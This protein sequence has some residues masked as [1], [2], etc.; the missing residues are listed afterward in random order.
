MNLNFIVLQNIPKMKSNFYSII[1]PIILVLINFIL[2]IRYVKY[3][4]LAKDEPFSLYFSQF[5]IV[6]IVSEL[7]KGNN[8]PLYEV[9]LHIWTSFFGISELAV[10]FPSVIFSSLTVYFIYHICRKFF[11]Q[12]AAILAALFFTLSNYEMY[13]AH[14]AR[15]YP[16]FLLLTTISM[17]QYLKLMT[18]EYSKA[19]IVTYVIVSILLLYSHFFSWYVL[20]IQ[21]V[22]FM[23]IFWKRKKELLKIS[24]YFGIIFL[25]YLPYVGVLANR[26]GG[27]SGG[28]WVEPVVNLRPLHSFYG[29]LVNDMHVNYIFILI[30]AWM[31]LQQ[32]I[33]KHLKNNILRLAAI[34]LSI[35]FILISL[36]I[37]IPL[38]P[39]END[40]SSPILIIS[41][42]LFYLI[43]FIH[44][45]TIEDHSTQGK[46]IISWLFIPGFLM[47]VVSFLMPMFIDRYL[48]YFTPA[49][50]IVLAVAISKYDNKMFLSVGLLAV[51]LMAVSFSPISN[52]QRDV[53]S[54]V[55]NIKQ[56]QKGANTVVFI[57]PEYDVFTFT[58][59]YNRDY[60][61]DI[62]SGIPRK[63]IVNALRSDD[64]FL[65]KSHKEVDSIYNANNYNKIIYLDVAAKFVY[66]NN[67]IKEYLNGAFQGNSVI[68][69]SLHVPRIYDI[70]SY[71][72]GH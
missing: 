65:V 52:N 50:F 8:P 64:I 15:V 43:L 47:F 12:K 35:T 56:M 69:D 70:Y 49:F 32:Y 14:E 68:I 57:C 66:P 39:F 23:F 58:Y 36:S 31:Y 44:Y 67:N 33:H 34:L 7:S 48:I 22:I 1:A 4:S 6:T 11:N 46:I 29:T 20:F 40:F 30:L 72:I 27:A 53:K 51:I 38:F 59:Y 26:F 41:F 63:D 62:R 25:F 55:E 45:Q 3:P 60:F 19:N 18:S 10:R 54:L 5:D 13:F 24:K 2:K 42:L 28:T 37:K 16:L 21:V 61:T 17:F 9:F 71:Q